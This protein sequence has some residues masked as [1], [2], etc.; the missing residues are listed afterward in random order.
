MDE[1]TIRTIREWERQGIVDYILDNKESNIED[2][3]KLLS[4]IKYNTKKNYNE[5]IDIRTSKRNSK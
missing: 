2:C 4:I 3:D 1:I 5:Q